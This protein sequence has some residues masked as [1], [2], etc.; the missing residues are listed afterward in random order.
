[1]KKT[2][3]FVAES[4]FSLKVCDPVLL[5]GFSKAFSNLR[6][7]YCLRIL[8]HEKPVKRKTFKKLSKNHKFQFLYYVFCIFKEIK[9]NVLATKFDSYLFFFCRSSVRS[10]SFDQRWFYRGFKFQRK[11]RLWVKGDLSL[12]PRI[13][14]M[15]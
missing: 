11:L 10:S 15:G 12:Q 8:N 7:K 13:H 9:K 6:Y 3:H 2:R 1:M 14:S 5:F 4:F